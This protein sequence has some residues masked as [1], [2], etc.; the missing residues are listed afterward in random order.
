MYKLRFLVF[1]AIISSAVI[2][3]ASKAASAQAK[4]QLVE[5]ISVVGYR[6]LAREEILSHISARVGEPFNW[7]AIERDFRSVLALGQ[8]DKL[9]SRAKIEPG[10]RG[11]VV[12]IFEVRE[13]PVV[14]TVTFH[15]LPDGVSEAD[16]TRALIADGVDVAKGAVFDSTEIPRAKRIVSKFLDAHGWRRSGVA[17]SHELSSPGKVAMTFEISLRF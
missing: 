6:R 12:V 4:P 14:E 11:G 17:V 15:G 7:D 8:F 13:L 10:A 1:A 2:C 3:G 9:H 16:L 5:E